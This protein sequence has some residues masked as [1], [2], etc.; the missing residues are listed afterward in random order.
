MIYLKTPEEIELI[1]E[2]ALLVSKTLGHI[3][4]MVKAGVDASSIG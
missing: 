2:A 1:K 4:P 3:A